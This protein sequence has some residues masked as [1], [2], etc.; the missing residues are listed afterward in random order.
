[1]INL[2]S[3]SFFSLAK[4]NERTNQDSCLPPVKVSNGYLFAIADG[5]GGYRGGKEASQL[6]IE[7]LFSSFLN[8]QSIDLEILFNSL[9]NDVMTLSITDK[10]FVN[11][12]TTLTFCYINNEQLTIGHIGDCRLF[13][14]NESKLI[15][16]TK[17][18]T[19]KQELLD[20]GV[21]TKKQLENAVIKNI[22]TTA[23]SKTLELKFDIKKIPI[24]EVSDSSGF[25]NLYLMSDGAHHF[26][27]KRPRFSLNTLIEPSKFCSSLKRR[28]ESGP[29]IDDYSLI[30]ILLKSQ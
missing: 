2:L 9:K 25:I 17:D 5:L 14:K 12:A 20:Q 27:E 16:L 18:H 1:M 21:F 24:S 30:S 26:W 19:Q 4:G 15:Q 8:D 13:Y 22:L 7:H 6:V 23:I 10:G 28:I 3:S 11:A 29:P